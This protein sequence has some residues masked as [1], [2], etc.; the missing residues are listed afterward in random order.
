MMKKSQII[1]EGFKWSLDLKTHPCTLPHTQTHSVGKAHFRYPH[2]THD[3]GPAAVVGLLEGAALVGTQST[4]HGPG[5][6]L[7]A[8]A[9][10]PL[11]LGDV[12]HSIALLGWDWK[13]L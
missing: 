5:G 10:Q 7:Q 2:G 12:W 8:P 1:R 13:R 9:T 3:M 6:R 4:V 11:A